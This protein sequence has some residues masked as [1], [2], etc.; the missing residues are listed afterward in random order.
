MNR[1]IIVLSLLFIM[2]TAS[3]AYAQ[4]FV[5]WFG[6]KGGVELFGDLAQTI[7]VFM[8]FY[9]IFRIFSHEATGADARTAGGKGW[10]GLKNLFSREEKEEEEAEREVDQVEKDTALIERFTRLETMLD[11]IKSKKLKNELHEINELHK[12]LYEL[13]KIAKEGADLSQYTDRLERIRNKISSVI[14]DM[15]Q[16]ERLIE[17]QKGLLINQIKLLRDEAARIQK[18]VLFVEDCCP[19][20]CSTDSSMNTE[21]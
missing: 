21:I 10:E 9:E 6:I 15:Q 5:D 12:V 4:G 11:N 3:G 14:K 13:Y 19:G 16:T 20:C 1:R 8:M 2:V 17:R 18:F 7:I